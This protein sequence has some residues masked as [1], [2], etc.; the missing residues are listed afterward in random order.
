M[1]ILARAKHCM[2]KL[3]VHFYN[4]KND[5]DGVWNKIV[6]YVDPPYCHCELEFAD[7]R[8]CA[9]YMGGVVH[10]KTRTFDP[11][12]Y[13]SLQY[14][15]SPQQHAR[16]LALAESLVASRQTF[17]NRCMLATK[18][19]LIGAPAGDSYTFCSKLCC[20]I[21]QAA[22]VLSPDVDAQRVTPSGLH[23]MLAGRQ[24]D[25]EQ[26]AVGVVDFLRI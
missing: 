10:L 21:M 25:R 17:S 15:C 19:N 1:R 6:S 5:K 2:Y 12:N 22:D 4:P 26:P 16:A 14:H 3:T 23:A 20:Q 11:A 8:S 24:H 13:D 18:I 7:A 9:V